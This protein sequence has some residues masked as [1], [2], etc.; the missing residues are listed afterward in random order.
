VQDALLAYGRY[1]VRVLQNKTPAPEAEALLRNDLL[2]LVPVTPDA[3][4]L[5]TLDDVEEALAAQ[6][7]ERGLYFLGGR[8]LPHYGPYI[9]KRTDGRAFQVELPDG[10]QEV[11]VHFLHEFL[12]RGWWHFN[13]YGESGAAGWAKWGEPDWPD[14]LY[15][16]YDAWKLDEGPENPA[17]QN[18]LLEH[19]AQHLIDFRNYPGLAGVDL[20]YRAKL[21]ELIYLS[22]LEDRFIW[23]LSEA[24]DDPAHP[25][26][27]AS[28]RLITAFSRH[29]FS[30]DYVRDEAKWREVEY[31]RIQKHARRLLAEHSRALE[32]QEAKEPN[33]NQ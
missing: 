24:Q 7:R 21:V 11:M 8:T 14:G 29:L 25:H 27:Q 13:T 12:M 20:E 31:G 19:E 15:C 30:E 3:G 2:P 32:T 18:S 23:L 22:A 6:F 1:F 16:V 17:F 28:Y 4:A 5:Q 33:G 10:A 9:W 26:S